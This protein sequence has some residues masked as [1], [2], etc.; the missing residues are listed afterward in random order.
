MENV[1]QEIKQFALID[2]NNVVVQVNSA[3]RVEDCINTVGFS[4]SDWIEV[5]SDPIVSEDEDGWIVVD[6]RPNPS[7]IGYIWNK[8][9]QNFIPPKPEKYPSW[10]LSEETHNWTPPIPEPMSIVSPKKNGHVRLI[11]EWDEQNQSWKEIY[12]KWSREY[13]MFF[14]WNKQTSS[15]Y[16]TEEEI[17]GYGVKI[18]GGE[19]IWNTDI[20]RVEVLNPNFVGIGTESDYYMFN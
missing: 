11:H 19:Y 4:E 18:H 6:E 3:A 13:D 17:D 8:E 16:C 7:G 15:W 20:P 10:I 2:E 14:T 5:N 1:E 12:Q 9:L